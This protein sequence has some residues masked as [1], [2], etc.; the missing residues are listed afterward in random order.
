MANIDQLNQASLI[1][2]KEIQII[3]WLLIRHNHIYG[4]I[5]RGMVKHFV[6]FGIRLIITN[7]KVGIP[8][9]VFKID[10]ATCIV[11]TNGINHILC[12]TDYA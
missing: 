12:K 5:Y 7:K 2:S 11:V 4:G 9:H 1:P 3:D 6:Q 10:R 8:T